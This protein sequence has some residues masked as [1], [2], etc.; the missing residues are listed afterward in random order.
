MTV[1]GVLVLDKPR[2]MSS[3]AAVNKVKRAFGAKRAGH[4]GTLDP[5]ATGV[6]AVCLGAATKLAPYLLADDKEYLAEGLLGSDTDTLDATGTT[7]RT[8]DASHVSREMIEAAI[9]SHPGQPFRVGDLFAL[10]HAAASLAGAVLFYAIVHVLPAHL[11]GPCRELA[12][13]LRPGGLALLAFHIG[14]ESN[15]VTELFGCA[16]D[17]DFQFH[18]PAQVSAALVAAGFAIEARLD[19]APVPGAEY[20]SQRCYL[21]AR[22]LAASVAQAGVVSGTH[23]P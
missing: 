19:R 3:A 13:V 7:V 1:H 11:D 18:Q 8:R 14:D 16:T 15:H 21:L 20:P 10:P 12:R 9:A 5:M 23:R 22:R 17:L 4:G 6:L 2:G